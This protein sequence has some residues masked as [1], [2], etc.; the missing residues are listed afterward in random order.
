VSKGF[1][2][3]MVV[4][5]LAMAAASVAE[6]MKSPEEKAAAAARAAEADELRA[7]EARERKAREAL[8]DLVEPSGDILE[9]A[10]IQHVKGN[11][12]SV[13]CAAAEYQGR[14]FV[15]CGLNFGGP[16]LAQNGLWEAAERNGALALY[17]MN[18]K[19]LRALEKIGEGERF[20]RGHDRPKVNL[21]DVRELFVN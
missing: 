4:L 15:Q 17:A 18:G 6:S 12:A 20:H 19:A 14:Y 11:A 21:S 5:A 8:E 10:Y 9:L 7:E 3:F 2:W 13:R 16:E 1:K